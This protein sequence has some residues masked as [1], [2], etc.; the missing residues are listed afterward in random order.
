MTAKSNPNSKKIAFQKTLGN[1]IELLDDG[2]YH[3]TIEPE[4]TSHLKYGDYGYDLEITTGTGIVKTLI[5][6]II[7]LTDEYTH[8]EDKIG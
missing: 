5:V 8:K 4:D 6:G 3:V 2:Y 7:T 1:G